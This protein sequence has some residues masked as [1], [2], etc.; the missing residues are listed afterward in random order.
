MGKKL[1][2]SLCDLLNKSQEKW[3][4]FMNMLLYHT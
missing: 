2:T 4:I 1:T 3:S